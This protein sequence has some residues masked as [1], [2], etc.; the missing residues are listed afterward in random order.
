MTD[1]QKG[2]LY[3]T[4]TPIGNL[5]DISLRA[6]AVLKGVD[7]ICAEDTRMTQQL[8]SSYGIKGP[9]L[10]SLREQNEVEQTQKV[11]ALLQ[12]GKNV[13]QVSDAGMPG[14]CDPGN[15]LVAKVRQAGF[16]LYVVPGAVALIAALSLTG[17]GEA[18][19]T[20]IGFLSAKSKERQEQ[21]SNIAEN[22]QTV[23]CYETPHRIE[24]TLKEQ[25]TI[26]P[27]R[28]LWL[29]RELTKKFETTLTG[30][31]KSLLSRLQEDPQ[32]K[33]GEMVIIFTARVKIED[34]N[35]SEAVKELSV[36]LLPFYPIKKVVSLVRKIAPVP[37]KR[38]YDYLLGVKNQQQV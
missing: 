15:R 22:N 19:F 5:K 26:D 34:D 6:L 24:A 2:T 1:L 14:I 30:D 18:P 27:A 32:Q 10:I 12:E 21:L 36:H 35:L 11:M 16:P 4:G 33:K 31:A 7:V 29:V 28:T 3:I 37:K 13:A 9:R 8:L 25:S 23:V 17:Q 38:L 20:F